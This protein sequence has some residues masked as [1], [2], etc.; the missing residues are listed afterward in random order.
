MCF[1][2]ARTSIDGAIST[3]ESSAQAVVY[4]RPLDIVIAGSR[5]LSAVDWKHPHTPSPRGLANCPEDAITLPITALA[6]AL[7]RLGTRFRSSPMAAGMLILYITCRRGPC[8]N[9][10]AAA[11]IS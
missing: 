4:L 10:P 11:L 8:V 2:P 3:S 6:A 5:P 7:E 1:N 9:A